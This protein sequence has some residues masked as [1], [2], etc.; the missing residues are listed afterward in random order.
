MSNPQRKV[1]RLTRDRLT[2]VET[3]KVYP[4]SFAAPIILVVLLLLA[5]FTGGGGWIA[6]TIIWGCIIFAGAP[7]VFEGFMA[8]ATEKREL[9]NERAEMKRRRGLK[10]GKPRLIVVP[11]G[12][13]VTIHTWSPRSWGTVE[14]DVVRYHAEDQDKQ[15]QEYVS[16]FRARD[17]TPTDKRRPSS[18]AQALARVLNS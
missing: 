6:A 3:V 12:E 14:H 16:E 9:R 13:N 8:N 18:E 15:A 4:R 1:D 17:H 10:R 11:E 7:L 5:I 2:L